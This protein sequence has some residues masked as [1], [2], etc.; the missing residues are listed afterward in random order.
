MDQVSLKYSLGAK[1]KTIN[2]KKD[3]PGP[4]DYKI[5]EI[6]N[7]LALSQYKLSGG[8]KFSKLPRMLNP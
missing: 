6:K 3:F 2:S 4:S 7:T 1:Y 5:P 8:S